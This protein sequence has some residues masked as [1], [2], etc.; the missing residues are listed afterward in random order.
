MDRD[1]SAAGGAIDTTDAT[2]PT[3]VHFN[4]LHNRSEHVELAIL[5]LGLATV[6]LVARAE[7]T[8]V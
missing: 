3:T 4:N 1:L 7:S 5:L 8:R 6:V 2:N